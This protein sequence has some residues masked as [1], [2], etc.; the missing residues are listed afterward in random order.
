MASTYALADSRS[1]Q[2]FGREQM[3]ELAVGITRLMSADDGGQ[4]E[5]RPTFGAGRGVLGWARAG[6]RGWRAIMML[7]SGSFTLPEFST[8]RK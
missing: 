4:P 6:T 5:G 3:S 1:L 8:D 7:A 2:P